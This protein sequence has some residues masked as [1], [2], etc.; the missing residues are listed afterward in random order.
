LQE[1]FAKVEGE[2]SKTKRTLAEKPTTSREAY[3]KGAAEGL[4]TLGVD[5]ET[6][7]LWQQFSLAPIPSFETERAWQDNIIHGLTSFCV[8]NG[9]DKTPA[10]GK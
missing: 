5:V 4:K 9:S 6:P 7:S 1:C 8:K 3:W 10:V 2:I